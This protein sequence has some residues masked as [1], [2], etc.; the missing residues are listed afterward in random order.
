MKSREYKLNGYKDLKSQL[1]QSVSKFKVLFLETTSLGF[2]TGMPTLTR[3]KSK[4]LTLK[5]REHK[6]K[7]YNN[8]K[9]QLLQSVLKFKVLFLGA[10]SLGFITD[11]P[12]LT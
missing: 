3:Q 11:M 6:I 5:L 10:T 1:L 12:T 9:S 8:L 2:I 4:E 7:H